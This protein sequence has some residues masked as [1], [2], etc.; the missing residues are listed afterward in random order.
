MLH[1]ASV[2]ADEA[3]TDGF[4]QDCI[5]SVAGFRYV[6]SQVSAV[7]GLPVVIQIANDR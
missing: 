2:E 4:Q 1:Q 7:G 6:Y 3:A 5:F